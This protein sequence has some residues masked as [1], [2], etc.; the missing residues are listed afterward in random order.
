[1]AVS[2]RVGPPGALRAAVSAPAEHGKAN[3]AVIELLAEQWRLPKSAFDV[4]RGAARRDKMVRISGE[5]AV[6][7][8]R[9]VAW[10]RRGSDG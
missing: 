2:W 3:G 6:L 7:V 1:M 10:V 5:P 8:E 4:A 9:I